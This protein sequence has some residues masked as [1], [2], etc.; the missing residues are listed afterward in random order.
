MGNKIFDDY[1]LEEIASYIDWTP[2]FHSW[3]MKGSAIQK[4]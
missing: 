4:Y 1:P 3:E 2:F